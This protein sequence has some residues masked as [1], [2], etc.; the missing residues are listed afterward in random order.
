MK[1]HRQF[2]AVIKDVS[3][4]HHKLDIHKSLQ[5]NFILIPLEFHNSMLS[6]TNETIFETK[7]SNT[8]K[9]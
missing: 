1:Q 3:L 7:A 2:H 9:R 4:L 8:I 6:K 5:I